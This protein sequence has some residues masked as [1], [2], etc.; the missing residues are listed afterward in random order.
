MTYFAEGQS[1]TEAKEKKHQQRKMILA[2]RFLRN[3]KIK[4]SDF[5]HT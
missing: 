2:L 5:L 4:L 1:E 3:R